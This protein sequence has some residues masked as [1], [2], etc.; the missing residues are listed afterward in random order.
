MTLKER[1]IRKLKSPGYES[2]RFKLTRRELIHM[3]LIAGGGYLMP[4]S[5]LQRAFALAGSSPRLPFLVFDLAGGA[6]MPGNFLVGGAGGPEDLVENYRQHGWNPRASNSL[7]RIFGLPMSRERSKMLEGLRQTLPKEITAS[8]SQQ[9]LKMASFAHFSLDDTTMNR[10]SAVS[11]VAKSGL[12]GQYVK[13]GLGMLSSPSG[14]NSDVYLR[15]AKFRPRAVRS[16]KDVMGLTLF[17]DDY[18]ELDART[19]KAIFNN[20]KEA[21]GNNSDLRDAYESIENLGISI[22]AMDVTQSEISSLYGQNGSELEASIVHNVL[23]GYTGPGVITIG[24]CDY[25]DNTVTT[26]DAK[27]L[28]IGQS[29]GRA[30]AAAHL[31]KKPLL[32]QIITDGGI[33]SRRSDNYERAWTGDANQH[34]LSVLAYFHPS[35]PVKL[36]QVQ[37]GH[38]TDGGQV[39]QSTFIGSGPEKM[40]L[41]VLLNYLSLTGNMDRFEAAS[42][43]RLAPD[44]IDKLLVFE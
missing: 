39:E 12:N 3:G 35:K 7:D 6:A 17:D 41:G 20:L 43:T 15:D 21:A 30:V 26:G 38:Y 10:S 27:D 5:R 2:H 8:S 25:H 40:A 29:I 37:V 31:L 19:R 4:L 16:S 1:L 42:G 34:G 13:A 32:I 14:G 18:T 23:N 24:N 9:M 33:Y 11:M 36:R 44:E 22:P 28:A